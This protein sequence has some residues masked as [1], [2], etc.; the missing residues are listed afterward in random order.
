MAPKRPI[1]AA[2]KGGSAHPK[3]AELDA[4]A[5]T[6]FPGGSG[7]FADIAHSNAPE[8]RDQRQFLREA[9]KKRVTPEL[10]KAV[11]SGSAPPS[12]AATP[13]PAGGA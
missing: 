6:A 10:L 3:G 2:P 11:G 8:A 1:P 4:M 9:H 13:R 7:H 5:A 12:P